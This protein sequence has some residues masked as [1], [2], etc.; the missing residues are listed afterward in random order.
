MGTIAFVDFQQNESEG[1]IRFENE[2]QALRAV[3]EF[4]KSPK[5]LGGKTPTI[6]L[7][8]GKKTLCDLKILIEFFS[9]ADDE[10]AYW[11]KVH[12]GK[13][14]FKKGGKGG[15]GKKQKRRRF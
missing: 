9:S 12:Q 6:V 5:E 2:E 1:Y 8:E 3:E 11:D 13:K 4:A 14:D 7:L 15:K 10:K